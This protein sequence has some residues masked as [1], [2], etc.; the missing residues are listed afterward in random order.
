MNKLKCYTIAGIIFVL[1]T[2]SLAHFLYDWI[3]KNAITGL[4]TP[5]NESV[6]EHIKLLF[7][8]ML[9]YSFF[10]IYKLKNEYP[11]II[12]SLCFGILAGAF[13]IPVLFY[14][15]TFLLGKDIFILDIAVFILSTMIAF[16]LSYGLTL[17]CT[18]KPYTLLLCSLT[19]VL[20]ACFV[21]FTSHP[22]NHKL[23]Q[24]PS[25]HE[26]AGAVIRHPLSFQSQTPV[27]R[28]LRYYF[29]FYLEDT[30]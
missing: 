9:L 21:I 27:I 25:L 29:S 20:F 4:F 8:P 6:W 11:C 13:F 3:G 26:T 30:A 16:G 23:F 7:F 10:M 17:S 1:V 14:T 24:D 15:Y 22:P 18:L 28:C 19:A 12:S 2:G 5:V